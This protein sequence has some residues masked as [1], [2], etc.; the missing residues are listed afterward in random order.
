M[1]V[2]L[3]GCLTASD[4]PDS[5]ATG[6]RL[7]GGGAHGGIFP[8]R[9]LEDPL[10]SQRPDPTARPLVGVAAGCDLSEP[11]RVMGLSGSTSHTATVMDSVHGNHSNCQA[12][13][14]S[15]EQLRVQRYGGGVHG[16]GFNGLHGSTKPAYGRRTAAFYGG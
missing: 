4:P 1:F 16:H 10:A 5:N 6:S 15:N 13:C 12:R 2:S 8:S 11:S 9:E 3:T 7:Q 14:G